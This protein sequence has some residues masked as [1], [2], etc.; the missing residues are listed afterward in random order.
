L[1]NPVKQ[2]EKRWNSFLHF[3]YF[4]WLAGIYFCS[5]AKKSR[6][7]ARMQVFAYLTQLVE[8]KAKIIFK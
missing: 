6:F 5:F 7:S 2:R 8:N 1:G 3:C 4:R